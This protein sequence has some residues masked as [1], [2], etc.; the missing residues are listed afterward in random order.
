[1][2]SVDKRSIYHL[3]DIFISHDGLG[4]VNLEERI[5]L[6]P[7]HKD[8]LTIRRTANIR[9]SMATSCQRTNEERERQQ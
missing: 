5:L 8:A 4:G 9:T 1:M 3:D 2:G 7:D 6:F